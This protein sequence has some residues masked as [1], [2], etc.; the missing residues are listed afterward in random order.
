MAP[1]IFTRARHCPRLATAHQ[2]PGRGSPKKFWGWTF[3]IGLKI[4][5]M[6][7]YNFRSSW[8][9][10]TK[11]YQGM[12]L[13]AGVITLSLIREG[14]KRPKFSA[15]CN[16]FR[17]WSQISPE[18][19]NISKIL[20]LF[21]QTHFIPY[22]AKK[23]REL[24]FTNKKVIGAHVDLPNWTFLRHYISAPRGRWPLKFLHA[25]LAP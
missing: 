23:I 16:N 6:R 3:K 22:C 2:K 15:I 5:H 18:R 21:H 9:N 1:Q 10:L 19:I 17:L 13:I 4:P 24:W 25:L 8:N 14:K 7:V 12:W 20:K 11:F